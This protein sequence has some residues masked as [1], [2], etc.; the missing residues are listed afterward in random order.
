MGR[1]AVTH[2]HYSKTYEQRKAIYEFFITTYKL[3]GMTKY[4]EL[5]KPSRINAGGLFPMTVEYW[6]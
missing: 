6:K 3:L 2:I 5:T 4:M 1:M